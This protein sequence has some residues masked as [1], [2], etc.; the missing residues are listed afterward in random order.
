MQALGMHRSCINCALPTRERLLRQRVWRA[1]YIHEQFHSSAMGCP[2]TI[3][4]GDGDD[5]DDPEGID[6]INIE[7]A[8][9]SSIL[10]D[11]LWQVYHLSTIT[12]EAAT[13]LAWCLQRWS[14]NPA[15]DLTIDHL[16]KNKEMSES[17]WTALLV[18]WMQLG[19]LYCII[20]L[21]CPFFVD[22]SKPGSKASKSS[23]S[24]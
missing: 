24:L 3:E 4:D 21:T 18:L 6:W 1:I 23:H 8:D 20:L 2:C 17:I 13:V 9:V 19:H 12:S 5:N 16:L 11:I 15:L 14:E 22:A 7:L 10:G